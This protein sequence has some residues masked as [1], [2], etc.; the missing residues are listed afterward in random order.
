MTWPLQRAGRQAVPPRMTDASAEGSLALWPTVQY[1]TNGGTMP[2][3]RPTPEWSAAERQARKLA[4]LLDAAGD[5]LDR[6][7]PV[8]A[9]EL[10]RRLAALERAW[11]AEEAEQRLD[12]A[13][14]R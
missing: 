13:D 5:D 3:D 2:N 10:Q 7:G 11:A 6:N 12:E 8:S 14:R 1:L 9:T 4:A